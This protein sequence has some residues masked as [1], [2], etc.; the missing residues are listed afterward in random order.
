MVMVGRGRGEKTGNKEI[1]D[2]KEEEGHIWLESHF[3][4]TFSGH[5]YIL[6]R[7]LSKF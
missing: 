6:R 7:V 3:K 5:V 4:A 2:G 1:R